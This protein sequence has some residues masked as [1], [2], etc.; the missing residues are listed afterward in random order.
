MSKD[1]TQ[2][3]VISKKRY[4]LFIGEINENSSKNFIK[5]LLKLELENPMKDIVVIIDSYGGHVD[6]MWSMIDVM[7]LCR[8][9]IH[10]LCVGKAMSCASLMLANG[11]KGKRYCTPH[12][13]VMLHKISA[14]N[15]G[16]YD[17]LETGM[18]ELT[19]IEELF[20]EFIVRKT[21]FTKKSLK[22]ALKN[23]CYLTAEQ[24]RQKGI[25]DKIIPSFSNLK[26]QGW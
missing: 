13:R 14:Y 23:N 4:I 1:L 10:T 12:A 25:V 7:D 6:S 3:E 24:A 26:L 8:C 16:S 19:R 15:N 9:K 11:T 5:E 2:E 21:R 20:E 17:D 18:K 22:D